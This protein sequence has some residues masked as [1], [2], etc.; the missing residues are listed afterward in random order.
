M[1]DGLPSLDRLVGE[2]RASREDLHSFIERL[3]R[4][5]DEWAKRAESL[6]RRKRL[7]VSQRQLFRAHL[8]RMKARHSP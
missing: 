2:T 7:T 6:V 5:H 3:R 4:D 1:P 8:T